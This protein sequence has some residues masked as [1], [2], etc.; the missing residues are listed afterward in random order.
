MLMALDR[1]V[2]GQQQALALV[3]VP[4][5]AEEQQRARSRLR[6]KASRTAV[7]MASSFVALN[8]AL[9]LLIKFMHKLN[10]A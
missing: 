3:R 1:F 9:R 8:K 2:A 5:E 10:D 7:G 6:Q 4:S